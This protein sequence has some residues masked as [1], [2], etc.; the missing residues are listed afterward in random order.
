MKR[1]LTLIVCILMLFSLTSCSLI[2]KYKY[3]IHDAVEGFSIDGDGVLVYNDIKY[4]LVEE[5]NGDCNVDIQGESI[6]LGWVSNFPFPGFHF[7]TSTDEHPE[8]ITGGPGSVAYLRADIYDNG[9][10]YALEDDTFEFEFSSEFIKTD[11]VN[12]E[13][14]VKKNKYTRKET[15]TFYIKDIPEIKASKTI[16][17][18]DNVWYS[19]DKG[20]KIGYQ[21]SDELVSKLPL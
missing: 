14:H 17:L 18:I 6:D 13:K 21:L 19:I 8:F 12:H 15:I 5:T 10:I 4:Y 2:K 9:I 3:S 11:K 1:I 16:Y 7:Y 20:A